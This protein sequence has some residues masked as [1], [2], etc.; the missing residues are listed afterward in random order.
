MRSTLSNLPYTI[1]LCF[2]FSLFFSERNASI[3]SVNTYQYNDESYARLN[4]Q[5][6][7]SHDRNKANVTLNGIDSAFNDIIYVDIADAMPH[8]KTY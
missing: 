6:S 4:I 1:E 8:T 5:Y 3:C 7:C 2:Q